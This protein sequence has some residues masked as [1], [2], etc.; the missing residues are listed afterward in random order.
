MPWRGATCVRIMA[1]CL[2]TAPALGHAQTSPSPPRPAMRPAQATADLS[3]RQEQMPTLPP[4]LSANLVSQRPVSRAAHLQEPDF[5]RQP[6]TEVVPTPPPTP[7]QPPDGRLDGSRIRNNAAAAARPST[8]GNWT[9]DDVTRLALEYNPILRRAQARIDS[10][11]GTATQA[12]LWANPRWDT[13]NPQVLGLGRQNAYNAGFQMDIPM[14]GKKKLDG[15]A[16]EQR[17]REAL[18]SY[19]S[20]RYDVMQNVRQA[21][22]TEEAQEWRV[23]TLR[24]L[25]TIASGTHEA[26]QKKFAV[27][28][29]RETEVLPLKLELQRAQAELLQAQALLVA[30]RRQLAA[31][32]GLP[33]LPISSLQGDLTRPL[34]NFDDNYIRQF[35]VTQNVDVLYAQTEV[36]RTR[37]LLRRAE[38]EPYPNIYTGPAA[39]WSASSQTQFWY[40]FQFNIP[41]WDRNQG[42]IRAA[43]A[44]VRDASSSVR[45]AQNRLL[46][47]AADA[48]GRHRAALRLAEQ[49]QREILPTAERYREVVTRGY[50]ARISTVVELFYA[51]RAFFEAKLQYISAQ[52]D[53]WTT[54]AEL[55]NLLQME[56]FPQ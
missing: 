43:N 22:I 46:S 40:N 12:Y 52:E 33:D 53:S 51:Q 5:D 50:Q 21:F 27:G 48:L 56:D 15:R 18:F 6:G 41:V 37:I 25:V 9:L 34:P 42:N 28:I 17:I 16:A 8:P 23:E 30:R 20:D 45:V 49:I 32:V 44:N 29:A 36:N 54:A 35:V 38:V 10:A 26:T 4:S 13:N 14:A 55:A 3:F 2:G 24:S 7:P 1:A 19:R 11:R 47:Q 31:A 39:Q